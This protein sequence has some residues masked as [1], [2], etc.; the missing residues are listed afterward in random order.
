M[1]LEPL[2]HLL[3]LDDFELGTVELSRRQ[4]DAASEY[5][6]GENASAIVSKTVIPAWL[7]DRERR[8]AALNASDAKRAVGK[9]SSVQ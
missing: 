2:R 3:G 4:L 8:A 5:T 9:D 7:I 1:T 6:E